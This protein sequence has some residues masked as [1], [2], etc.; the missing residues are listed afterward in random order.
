MPNFNHPNTS[1]VLEPLLLQILLLLSEEVQRFNE[2]KELRS[3]QILNGSYIHSPLS[4]DCFTYVSKSYYLILSNH[5]SVSSYSSSRI[6]LKKE[7][8]V[9]CHFLFFVP[10]YGTLEFS[11]LPSSSIS[12]Y[13]QWLWMSFVVGLGLYYYVT[14]ECVWRCCL[15]S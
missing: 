14:L 11:S 15:I 12:L 2:V 8:N 6:C 1:A 3:W 10:F 5:N 4:R 7:N 13:S 9:R